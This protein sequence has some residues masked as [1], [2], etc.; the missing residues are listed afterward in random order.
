M[1]RRPLGAFLGPLFLQVL[2]FGWYGR[3]PHLELKGDSF[4]WGGTYSGRAGYSPRPLFACGGVGG[5]ECYRCLGQL[6]SLFFSV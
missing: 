2:A 5:Q 6:D 3:T 1:S 4:S